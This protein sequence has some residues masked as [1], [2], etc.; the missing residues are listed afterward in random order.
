[1]IAIG[2]IKL[3]PLAQVALVFKVFQIL[4][5]MF[6]YGQSLTASSG[7]SPMKW[8]IWSN[9]DVV[10]EGLEQEISRTLK[11]EET[12]DLECL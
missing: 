12:L 1:L 6:N 7:W 9:K 11:C 10:W 3:F 8:N 4:N 5:N 2:K